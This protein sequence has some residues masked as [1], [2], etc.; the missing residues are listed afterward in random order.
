MELGPKTP[1]DV[2]MK[3]RRGSSLGRRELIEA[4]LITDNKKHLG[5]NEYFIIS[6]RPCPP[7]EREGKL[8][9]VL[10]LMLTSLHQASVYRKRAS[11]LNVSVTYLMMTSS[12]ATGGKC[13]L[14]SVMQ[15]LDHS[16]S[17]CST[18]VVCR[19]SCGGHSLHSSPTVST[20]SL[21]PPTTATAF[22]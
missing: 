19:T 17:L 18:L 11:S 13:T 5:V 7:G 6:S 10:P 1:L 15:I 12:T 4:K 16:T 14:R 8:T 21:A 2:S 20:P 22:H 3:V 9:L